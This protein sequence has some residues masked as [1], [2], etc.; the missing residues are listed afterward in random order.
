MTGVN[1]GVAHKVSGGGNWKAQLKEKMQVNKKLVLVKII[2]FIFYAGSTA[3]LPYLTLHMQTLG[4]TVK[5]IAIIYTFLPISS[6]LGPPISGVFADKSGRYMVVMVL[7]ILMSTLFHFLLLYVEPRPLNSLSLTCGPSGHHLTWAACNL[8]HHQDNDTVLHLTLKSCKYTCEDPPPELQMCLHAEENLPSCLPLTLADELSING[9]VLSWREE[10]TCSHSWYNMLY[11]GQAFSS[12]TC[13]S[14]CPMECQV[15]GAPDC[16][17]PDDPSNNTNT[18]WIYFTLRMIGTFFL[19]SSFT[20]ADATTLAILK[21]HKGNFGVQ[22]LYCVI[23]LS[24]GPLLSG[25]LVDKYSRNLGVVDYAPAF[26]LGGAL[27]VLAAILTTRLQFTVDTADDKVLK[28]LWQLV[29][30]VEVDAFLFMVLAQGSNWGFIESF[31]FVY[32]KELGAPTYLLGLTMTV[33]NLVGS[34]IMIVMD[35]MVEKLGRHVV[36][37]ISFF[38]YA[39]RHFG[40]SFI[41]NPW[42]VFPFEILEVFT[43][44][45]MWLA[46]LTYCPI[47]APKGLLATMTGLAGS[48]HYSLGR[49]VGSLLGGFL[50]ASYGTSKSFRIFAYISIGCGFF[51]MIIHFFYLKHIVAERE[52]QHQEEAQLEK[53]EEEKSMLEEQP[54]GVIVKDTTAGS[55][56]KESSH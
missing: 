25:F 13:P 48:I 42:W 45:L 34:P 24:V 12:L 32:L 47:L 26:Y 40:Y 52:A 46:A 1:D 9:T 10:E 50:I 2:L 56:R 55:G 6:I 43:Y 3:F 36:F 41:T 16:S 35:K 22:R 27:T 5:E 44:Q 8:C 18:F 23:G 21:E 54:L 39:I 49:G 33:G 31:L 15:D 37:V 29:T 51:Y 20:M 7:N 4:I 30:R 19:S 17:H 28:K 11:E 14:Q 38:V 53:P